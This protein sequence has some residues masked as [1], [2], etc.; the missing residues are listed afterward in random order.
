MIRPCGISGSLLLPGICADCRRCPDAPTGPFVVTPEQIEEIKLDV[1]LSR[2]SGSSRINPG[3]D[4]DGEA[5]A[6]SG[7]SHD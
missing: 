6:Y 1:A 3:R 5:Q 2:I 7:F 4:W